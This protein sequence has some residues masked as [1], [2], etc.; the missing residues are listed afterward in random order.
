MAELLD[1]DLTS[2][3][4]P[5]HAQPSESC[6]TQVDAARPPRKASIVAIGSPA[7]MKARFILSDILR[8][9]VGT[10][11]EQVSTW[12]YGREADWIVSGH[13]LRRQGHHGRTRHGQ[14]H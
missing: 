1:H 10:N 4:H 11:S 6:L 5:G 14:Y 13:V 9:A 2:M 12:L 8:D 7:P 3:A